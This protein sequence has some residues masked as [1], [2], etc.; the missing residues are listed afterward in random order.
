MCD[1]ACGIMNKANIVKQR[2]A[3]KLSYINSH[4]CGILADKMFHVWN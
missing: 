1:I 4:L 2:C 3:K